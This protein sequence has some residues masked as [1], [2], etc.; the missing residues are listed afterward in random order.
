MAESTEQEN[1]S[2]LGAFDYAQL[3]EIDTS[4]GSLKIRMSH[5]PALQGWEIRRQ[6]KEF[7]ESKDA[8][9]RVNFTLWILNFCYV[10]NS[11]GSETEI[12]GVDFVNSV[13]EKWQN[14][15]KV[16][17]AILGLNGI[18]EDAEEAER[19]RW[20]VAGED[21]AASFLAAVSATIGPALTFAAS[22]GKE[23]E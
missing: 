3:I 14:I 23:S 15:D 19:R 18:R 8:E 17:D 22:Q 9:F 6:Y 20:Q 5:F 16:I 21:M 4:K 11:D 1:A 2:V 12:S 7:L 10:V 13:L